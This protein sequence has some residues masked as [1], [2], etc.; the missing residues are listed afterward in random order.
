[1]AVIAAPLRGAA[2]ATEIAVAVAAANAI[3]VMRIMEV[4]LQIGCHRASG[5]QVIDPTAY[6]C[7]GEL[8]L[9]MN[10]EFTIP[11]AS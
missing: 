4:S 1:M 7:S 9:D 3:M 2:E 6:A 11:S 10:T 5:I 8:E